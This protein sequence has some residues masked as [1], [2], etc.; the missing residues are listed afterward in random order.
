[1]PAWKAGKSIIKY[2]HVRLPANMPRYQQNPLGDLIT[3]S[4][5]GIILN[6]LQIRIAATQQVGPWL[7]KKVFH[8]I[9]QE[10][11][12]GESET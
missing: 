1:M 2:G 5:N 9:G 4:A 12:T 8:A 10:E 3:V 11:S 6:V 7:A